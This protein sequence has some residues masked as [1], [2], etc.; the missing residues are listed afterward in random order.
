MDATIIP[1]H[2][3]CGMNGLLSKINNIL[4]L[5]QFFLK[6]Y[7][8][9]LQLREN[10][11]LQSVSRRILMWISGDCLQKSLFYDAEGLGSGSG[12]H[13]FAR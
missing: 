7:H 6:R 13:N 1:I 3:C 5:Y 11:L 12:G 2:T 9:L 8:L 10:D 4:W